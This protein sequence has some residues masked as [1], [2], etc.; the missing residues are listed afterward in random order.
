M[1]GTIPSR[2]AAATALTGLGA[3]SSA[4]VYREIWD[5]LAV[6]ADR[7]LLLT[8]DFDAV[9]QYISEWRARATQE[10]LK[11]FDVAEQAEKA[12]FGPSR[13]LSY[14]ENTTLRVC[15]PWT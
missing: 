15:H 4:L 1:Y 10:Y 9:E 8:E 6:L 3:L 2:F 11:A 5:S 14:L 12:A 13:S 7:D